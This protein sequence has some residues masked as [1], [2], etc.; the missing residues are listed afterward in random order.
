MAIRN[1]TNWNDPIFRKKSR[2]VDKFDERLLS[3]L[4][5]MRDT[6]EKVGGYVL[7]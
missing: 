6:L 7:P 5:D 1:L 3:L 2:E 4:G